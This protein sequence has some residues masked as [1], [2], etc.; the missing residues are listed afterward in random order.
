MEKGGEDEY[1]IRMIKGDGKIKWYIKVQNTS[2][3]ECF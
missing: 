1:N 3:Q 2:D